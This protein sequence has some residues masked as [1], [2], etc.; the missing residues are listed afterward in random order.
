MAALDPALG[1]PCFECGCFCEAEYC[2][3]CP[4]NPCPSCESV[5]A[6]EVEA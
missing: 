2:D 5:C 4:G 6:G 3:C 1:E